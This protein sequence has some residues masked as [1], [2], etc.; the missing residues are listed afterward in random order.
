MQECAEVGR[1]R[2]AD[3]ERPF[4]KKCVSAYV[5]LDA[6][7]KKKIMCDLKN[8]NENGSMPT[9]EVVAVEPDELGSQVY[10][11]VIADRRHEGKMS[12]PYAEKYLHR[13]DVYSE[14]QSWV[15]DSTGKYRKQIGRILFV[16]EAVRK[17]GR[18]YREFRKQLGNYENGV[19]IMRSEINSWCGTLKP[20]IQHEGVKVAKYLWQLTAYDK[21]ADTSGQVEIEAVPT[22]KWDVGVETTLVL[23]LS[24][25]V[26][27]ESAEDAESKVNDLVENA[28]YC[29]GIPGVLELVESFGDEVVGVDSHVYD[30]T[31]R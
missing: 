30:A 21:A 10:E 19:G 22:K 25:P 24:V 6:G 2:E 26:T 7:E 4:T 31:P 18:G 14:F 1:P 27:A 17:A 11:F 28:A 5:C 3:P 15:Y 9:A 23:N 20:E 29:Y 13:A 12:L 16:A 8:A